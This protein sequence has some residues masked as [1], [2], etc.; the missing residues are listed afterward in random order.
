[1]TCVHS[2]ELGVRHGWA[3]SRSGLII[4]AHL[5]FGLVWVRTGITVRPL[6]QCDDGGFD[7][8][9][10][11]LFPHTCAHGAAR[12]SCASTIF[13]DSDYQGILYERAC[14]VPGQFGITALALCE[15]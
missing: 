1:M 15:H 6:T 2:F 7:L 11:W 12:G 10:A 8:D 4:I 3:L 13:C 5:C 14:A 9:R